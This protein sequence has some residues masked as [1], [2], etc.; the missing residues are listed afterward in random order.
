MRSN[1]KKVSLIAYTVIVVVITQLPIN[2]PFSYIGFRHLSFNF[3]P[4][5]CIINIA[6]IFNEIITNGLPL[7]NYFFSVIKD[8]LLNFILNILLFIPFGCLLTIN[9]KKSNVFKVMLGSF[10]FSLALET[11]Q[12]IEMVFSMTH[13]RVL[14]IDDIIANIFGGII[15]FF[16]VILLS[17]IMK[18]RLNCRT[19]NINK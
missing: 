2:L 19:I 3:T 6:E 1:I 11:L 12:V 14:D 5:Y 16:F 8:H 10:L 13:V 15:G 17:K 18:S 7:K 4:F 9:I